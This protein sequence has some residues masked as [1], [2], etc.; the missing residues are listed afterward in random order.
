MKLM[1]MVASLFYVFL[2]I[3]SIYVSYF[4]SSYVSNSVFL[5]TNERI[6][7][8]YLYMFF[9]NLALVFGI[10]INLLAYHLKVK[11]KIGYLIVLLPLF[12]FIASTYVLLS[13][14]R[15]PMVWNS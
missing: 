8:D 6:G 4:A 10:I 1:F 9:Q 12:L 3:I 13:L 5:Y 11:G 2:S 7:I 15:V 14:H